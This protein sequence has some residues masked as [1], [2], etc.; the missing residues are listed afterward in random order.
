MEIRTLP[1]S[2]V[3]M[4]LGLAEPRKPSQVSTMCRFLSLL[5]ADVIR[6]SES[7]SE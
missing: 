3:S 6:E 2:E 5:V 7:E 4:K 1:S